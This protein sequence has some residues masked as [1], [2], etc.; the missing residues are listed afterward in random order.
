MR[1]LRVALLVKN[2]AALMVSSA[3]T[4]ILGVAFWGV[5]TRMVSPADVG[6]SSAEIAAMMLVATLA[7]LGLPSMFE[8][9]LPI[10]GDRAHSIVI[11]AY[12]I[13][14]A[15]SVLLSVLYI[16]L[17][18]SENFLP[19][20]LIWRVVFVGS[21]AIWTVFALQ[22][23]VLI[24]LRAAR[25]VPVE[26]ILYSLAKLGLVPL[27]VIWSK[28]DAIF[29]AWM[30]PLI[31]AIIGVNWYL[32]KVRI[33]RHE[34]LNLSHE[35]FPTWRQLVSMTFAQY[36]SLIVNALAPLVVILIVFRR[37]GPVASAHYYIPA[38]I[39]GGV[40][41]FLVSVVR[42]FLVEAS[43]EPLKIR[44]HARVALRTSAAVVFVSVGVGVIAAP[45]ILRI[46]GASYSVQG[47]TLLRLMLLSIVGFAVSDYYSA[48]AWIDRKIWSIVLRELILTL[49]YFGV[50]LATISHVGILSVGIAS[51]TMASLQAIVFLGP[52]I[53]RYRDLSRPPGEVTPI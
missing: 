9:F 1:R 34:G 25:W 19:S 24:G 40:S 48:L 23:S 50:I 32:F 8:R 20:Q 3:G 42:S 36:A 22:D 49:L 4:S 15:A 17:G 2:A 35:T 13:C 46:F 37:L 39:A 18:F 10:S 21:V 47:T 11:R 14:V 52:L 7:Q 33:P 27:L 28:S 41:Q 30:S 6:R 26:N 43:T 51:I 53:K 44:R 45:W 29:A 12:G 5:A 31:G 16:L 38:Q